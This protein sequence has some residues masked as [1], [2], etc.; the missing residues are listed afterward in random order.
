MA[1]DDRPVFANRD[2][3]Q[4]PELHIPLTRLEIAQDAL[5]LAGVLAGMVAFVLRPAG[6]SPATV[7]L[8]AS[9]V[10]LLALFTIVRRYPRSYNY[11]VRITVANAEYQYRHARVFLGW[12]KMEIVWFLL[13]FQL[14]LELIA[15][16]AT[17]AFMV[18]FL[19]LFALGFIA[20]HGTLLYYIFS[21]V[22]AIG[23]QK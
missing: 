7:V 18:A 19:T 23:R 11:I 14:L 16:T 9:N 3:D 2:K 4:R 8:L 13:G 1:V 15:T 17:A 10:F 21:V 5:S 12:M 22:P 6:T 20:I